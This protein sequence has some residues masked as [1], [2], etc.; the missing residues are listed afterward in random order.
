MRT[1][2]TMRAREVR[3]QQELLDAIFGHP[4]QQPPSGASNPLDSA[5]MDRGIRAYQANAAAHAAD[6][7]RARYPTLVAMLGAPSLDALALRH[8]LEHPP[9]RGDLAHFG[10]TFP[11]WLEGIPE[12]HPWPWLADSARLDNAAWDVQF[13]PPAALRD[14]DLRRLA[15]I[16]PEC[17]R[18]QLAPGIRLVESR[19]PIVTLRRLHDAAQPDPEAIAVALNGPGEAAWVWRNETGFA[20]DRLDPVHRAWLLALSLTDNLAA[21]LDQA[22]EAFDAAA[23]LQ[24]AVSCGWIHSVTSHDA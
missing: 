14:D 9:A 18:L 6:A 21:A 24:R 5:R 19:W 17:L 16:P 3:R 12:L 15:S 13:A 8:W 22:P 11:D 1:D 4:G 20:L 7:V 10:A 23:W 2:P